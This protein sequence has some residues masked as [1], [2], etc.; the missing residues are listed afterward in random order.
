[1]AHIAQAR[2]CPCTEPR[3]LTG[4]RE[5]WPEIIWEEVKISPWKHHNRKNDLK[6]AKTFIE[7]QKKK[8]NFYSS[9]GTKKQGKA[10]KNLKCVYVVRKNCL[11]ARKVAWKRQII[12]VFMPMAMHVAQN[13]GWHYFRQDFVTKLGTEY[14]KARQN[15]DNFFWCLMP[16]GNND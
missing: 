7:K 6:N 5:R 4:L 16:D 11:M 2:P 14:C 10:E 8:T 9:D 15:K 3:L 13:L 12:F 1:M